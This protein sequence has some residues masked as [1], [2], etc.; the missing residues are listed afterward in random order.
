MTTKFSELILS[1][2][3]YCSGNCQWILAGVGRI[4]DNKKAVIISPIHKS[5]AESDVY[6]GIK[7]RSKNCDNDDEAKE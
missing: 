3:I 6:G 4:R 2:G 5:A 1:K 7:L